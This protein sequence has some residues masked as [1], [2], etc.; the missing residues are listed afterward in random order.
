MGDDEL[1]EQIDRDLA[2]GRLE[3]ACQACDAT[4]PTDAPPCPVCGCAGTVVLRAR[5]HT[6][7]RFRELEREADMSL[8]GWIWYR[9]TE[10]AR[11]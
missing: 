11:R 6:L 2:A 7:R 4:L 3:R 1:Q 9:L 10:W 5:T 8:I